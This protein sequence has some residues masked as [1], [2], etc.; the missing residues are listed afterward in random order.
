MKTRL[1]AV[2]AL[3]VVVIMTVM[4]IISVYQGKQQE[5]KRKEA[6]EV[7]AKSVVE[8]KQSDGY[9][10]VKGAD[11][12]NLASE[13]VGQRIRIRGS[14]SR[15][16][17]FPT[18]KSLILSEDECYFVI[19]PWGS[20]GKVPSDLKTQFEKNGLQKGDKLT[21][22]AE[23][24]MLSKEDGINQSILAYKSCILKPVDSWSRGW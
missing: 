1:K 6:T 12:H 18:A 11:L 15:I 14:I 20:L 24:D 3:I 17:R 19:V 10:I 9:Y 21:L 7:G 5:V 22:F 4:V 23:I 13:L 2:F 8:L 16:D